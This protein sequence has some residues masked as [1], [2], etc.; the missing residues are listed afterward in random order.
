M[1]RR[2][3]TTIIAEMATSPSSKS[4]EGL[5]SISE[6]DEDEDDE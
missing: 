1:S 6:E 3:F 5:N 4:D 2:S